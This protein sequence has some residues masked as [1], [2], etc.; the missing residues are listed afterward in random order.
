MGLRLRP[1]L[2]CAGPFPAVPSAHVCTPAFEMGWR[3]FMLLRKCVDK[4]VHVQGDGAA[5]VRT[6]RRASTIARAWRANGEP[7]LRAEQLSEPSHAPSRPELLARPACIAAGGGGLRCVL[8]R[9]GAAAL[10]AV[11]A[12]RTRRSAHLVHR[13][14]PRRHAQ[15]PRAMPRRAACPAHRCDPHSGHGA[16]QRLRLDERGAHQR[17]RWRRDRARAADLRAASCGCRTWA[18]IPA[19]TSSATSGG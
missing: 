5:T 2:T 10:L 9:P 11:R 1:R 3:N 8:V 15:R 4:S 17:G 12:N 13:P 16:A 14:A 6:I 19:A 18:R 7:I